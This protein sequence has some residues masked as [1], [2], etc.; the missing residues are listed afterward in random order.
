[1]SAIYHWN[2]CI[3]EMTAK[4]YGS[5]YVLKSVF[6]STSTGNVTTIYFAYFQSIMKHGIFL[7]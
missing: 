7:V 1:M 6:Q 4:L 3:D 2:N 5:G